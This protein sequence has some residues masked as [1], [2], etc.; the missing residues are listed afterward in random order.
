MPSDEQ[1]VRAAKTRAI[2][3]AFIKSAT[4]PLS[5]TSIV[6]ELKQPLSAN[7]TTETAAVAMLATM[8]KNDLIQAIREDGRHVLYAPKDYKPLVPS[9]QQE[10]IKTTS[11]PLQIDYIQ[12][13]GRV[14]ITINN[15]SIEIGVI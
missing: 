15:I 10:I 1:M 2:L 5:A 9:V 4:M 6:N 8:A 3:L 13:T 12:K 7:K 14:R 11:K